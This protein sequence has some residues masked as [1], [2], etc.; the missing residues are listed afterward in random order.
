VAEPLKRFFDAALVDRLAESFAGE[1]RF[2]A[3]RFRKLARGGLEQLELMER[4][5]HLMKALGASLPPDYP[6]AIELVLA[7][8]GPPLEPDVP[9]GMQPFFYLPHTLFV[10]ERG[11]A[12]EHFELSMR[13]QHALTQRFTCEASI[14]PFLERQR[15]RTLARLALWASDPSAHVRRLVS[16]GTRPRLPWAPRV[17]WL[18]AEPEPGLAL[19]ERLKDDP[20]EF[21]RRSVANHLNDVAK[22][23]PQRV[24]ELVERWTAG[25]SEERRRTA[26]AS[27]TSKLVRHALRTLVKRG[28]RRALALLGFSGKAPPLDVRGRIAPRSVRIGGRVEIAAA[29]ESR[30]RTRTRVVVDLVVHYVKASGESA[31]KIFKWK[32]LA[33]DPRVPIELRRSLS[34]EQRTTRTHRPGLHRVELQVQG[35]RFPLGSFRLHE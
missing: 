29:L 20:S 14:R 8:L 3:A 13:A 18:I 24:L 35:E 9:A 15:E 28:D 17:S 23:H 26:P 11:L 21:V 2:D 5:R 27:A 6:E 4:G 10:A 25:A 22:D 34:L 33:L 16:E 30:A 7:R 31:P 1:R 32:E 12:P 19:C